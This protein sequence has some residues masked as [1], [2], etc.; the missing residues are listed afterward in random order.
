MYYNLS[1]WVEKFEAFGLEEEETELNRI[2]FHKGVTS[3]LM[4]SKID[5]DHFLTRIIH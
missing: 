4:I 1:E 5:L 3:L 2:H